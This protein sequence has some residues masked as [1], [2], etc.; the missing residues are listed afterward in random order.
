MTREERNK[1]KQKQIIHEE[2]KEK[3]LKIVFSLLKWI[4][5]IIIAI[6]LLVLY[7]RYLGTSGL[8]VKENKIVSETIPDPFHGFKII[9]FSDLHYGSTVFEKEIKH[10]TREINKRKPDLIVFTGDLIDKN[11]NL[12]EDE[13]QK[14]IESFQSLDAKVGKYAVT[15]NHDFQKEDFDHIMAE[16]NFT[17]LKNQSELIYY[18]GYDPILL[19]GLESSIKGFRNIPQAFHY[20]EEENHNDNIYTITLLHEPDSIDTILSQYK[21]NLALAGHSHNGQIQIPYFGSIIKVKGAKK[22]SEAY[23]KI[24]NT[25]LFVSGGIGTSTYPFRLFNRPSINFFRITKK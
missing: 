18:E 21:T 5:F 2:Q 14:L 4:F 6:V 22:Y 19:V 9:Q 25:E 7:T 1:K 16:S 24:D 3:T 13:R 12:K 11:Y 20:F 23:Y 10:L 8:I 15:G 17:V